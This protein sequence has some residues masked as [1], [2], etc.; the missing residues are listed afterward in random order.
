MP[1]FANPWMF[2][3]LLPLAFAAWR[4]LRCGRRTGV[5]FSAVGRLPARTSGW[6]AYVAT[7]V[8]FL[9]VAGLALLVVAAARPRTPREDE[10]DSSRA[11]DTRSVESIA[12][13][14]VVDVSGSMAILDLA[15][16]AVQEKMRE[17]SPRGALFRS[18]LH[19]LTEREAAELADVS[20]LAVVKRLFAEFVNRRPDD[21]IGLV[22]FGTYA[23]DLVPLTRDHQTLLQSLEKVEIPKESATAIGD[24]LALA[25]NRLKGSDL[26]SKVIVLLSDGVQTA[27]SS[28]DPEQVADIAR[29]EGIKI[30]AIGIGTTAHDMPFVD[31][32][33]T[34]RR[35]NARRFVRYLDPNRENAV[36]DATQLMNLAAKT[37]G[38]YSAA[39]DRQALEEALAK[40][41][42][43]EKTKIDEEE[44]ERASWQ[45][46]QEHFQGCLWAGT[47]LVLA[48]LGISL[49]AS[50]RL[51]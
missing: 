21:F 4:L 42:A 5:R 22:T 32:M 39:N 28:A 1:D 46:W 19:Q 33:G 30:H 34:D 25:I 20:R 49:Y 37:H 36:F 16:P 48:A 11:S 47:A 26:A 40:I 24:G 23:S 6:R 43:L 27:E 29:R 3:L 13:V 45:L 17:W 18:G 51:A 9:L 7:A 10:D 35:G 12:I 38:T 14:M 2:L 41:D 44:V 8:P 31:E 50:R 15:P